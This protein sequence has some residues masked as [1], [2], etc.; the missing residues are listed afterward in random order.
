MAGAVMTEESESC[1]TALSPKQ[2]RWPTV[3]QR[4]QALSRW[5]PIA[6]PGDMATAEQQNNI[7]TIAVAKPQINGVRENE[8]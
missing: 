1:Y 2:S 8:V 5:L 3:R 6:V 4:S 7:C